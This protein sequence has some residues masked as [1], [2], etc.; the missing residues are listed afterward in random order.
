[1]QINGSLNT[2]FGWTQF[3]Y[4]CFY[5]ACAANKFL[6]KKCEDQRRRMPRISN[7]NLLCFRRLRYIALSHRALRCSA[8]VLTEQSES[9]YFF[10][11]KRRNAFIKI[12]RN[13]AEI[14][15]TWILSQWKTS[16]KVWTKDLCD[17]E[18]SF[19]WKLY[20]LKNSKNC[21]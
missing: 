13:L 7:G 5:G 6:K 12:W 18:S 1:M 2:V 9:I 20:F 4:N 3:F 16:N 15:F 19:S 21:L 10:E 11:F 17:T 14:N 8:Y